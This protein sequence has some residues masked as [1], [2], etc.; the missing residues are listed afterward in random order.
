MRRAT[1]LTLALLLAVLLSPLALAVAAL[2][3]VFV[4]RPVLFHQVRIGRD[5]RPFRIVKFRTMRDAPK[6]TPDARRTPAVG[7]L[8]RRFSLDELPELWNVIRGDMALIGPRPLLKIEQPKTPAVRRRRASVRPGITG[9]AQING[10]NAITPD[11]KFALDLDWIERRSLA[12]D[13]AILARTLI[14]VAFRTGAHNA[15]GLH[16]D[17]AQAAARQPLGTARPLP[18]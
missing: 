7:A 18:A 4:A 14:C 6:G 2:V 13:T 10:R 3:A 5:G 8:L 12:M 15:S 17:R 1:D 16:P 11:R 9:W